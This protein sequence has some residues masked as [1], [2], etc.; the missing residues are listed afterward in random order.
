MQNYPEIED[1][2]YSSIARYWF[3]GIQGAKTLGEFF[4]ISLRFG[5]INARRDD[6]NASVPF[7]A[8]L[9]VIKRF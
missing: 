4:E 7:Y 2:W 8:Q 9:G 1:G 6:E 5:F 3:Y